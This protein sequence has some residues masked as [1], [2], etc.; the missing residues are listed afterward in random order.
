MTYDAKETSLRGGNPVELYKA[1][2]GTVDYL[3]NDSDSDIV[4]NSE[5][6]S[7]ITISRSSIDQNDEI[8]RSGIKVTVPRD[9]DLADVFRVYAPAEVVAI[10]IFRGHLDDGEFKTIWSGRVI[11][12]DWSGVKAT[13]ECESVFSS[14]KRPGLRRNYQAQCPH[15]LY[16][17]ACGLNQ[18][19]H[20]TTDNVSVISG[21]TVSVPAASGFADGYF[22]G[23]F[24]QFYTSTGLGQVRFI[25]DHTSDVLTL[26]APIPEL[27]VSDSVNVFPGCKHTLDDCTN[28]FDNLVNYGG[29][30][31][32]P[33]VNPFGGGSA[34]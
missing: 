13:L 14:L 21:S 20:Q 7:P 18:L 29:F 30:P 26:V 23:G 10:T 34:F 22:N 8:N 1:T 31:Y 2:L 9:N 28:K 24:L 19:T 33:K 12:C 5:T 25:A 11:S 32:V 27:S 4:Y 6:Y 3:Y 16:G 17:V 15:V